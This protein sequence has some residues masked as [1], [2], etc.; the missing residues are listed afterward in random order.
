[1]PPSQRKKKLIAKIQE[2][3]QKIQQEQGARDGLIKMK[4]VYESNTFLGDPQTVQGE[5]KE[6]EHK[7]EKLKNEMRKYQ[8]LLEEVKSQQSAQHSPQTN[9]LTHP[10]NG[11]GNH[12][13][14]R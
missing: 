12:R 14:S 4:G 7:L 6:C 1:L 9:R 2:I 5:L 8:I 3:Q 10:N 13:S 11:H